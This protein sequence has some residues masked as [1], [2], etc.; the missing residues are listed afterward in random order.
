VAAIEWMQD[1]KAIEL[2]QKIEE[3]LYEKL[4]QLQE[5]FP[6]IIEVRGRG[7]MIAIEFAEP[8]SHSPLPELA[9]KV[10]KFCH[11]NGVVVLVTGT[12]GNVIRFLPPLSIPIP[13]LQ[14]ALGVLNDAFNSSLRLTNDKAPSAL[15]DAK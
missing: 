4:G 2:A 13:A 14:D 11:E 3:I 15:E 12:H 7:A 6:Q 5:R 8:D 10:A 9:G 1:A